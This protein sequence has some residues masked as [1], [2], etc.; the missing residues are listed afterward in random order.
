MF[1]LLFSKQEQHSVMMII[2]KQIKI[3]KDNLFFTL[4]S[5]TLVLLYQGNTVAVD[6]NNEWKP[7]K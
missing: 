7:G 3:V 2:L 4:N 6:I 5:F 1:T